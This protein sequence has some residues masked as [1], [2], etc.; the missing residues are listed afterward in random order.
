MTPISSIPRKSSTSI[1]KEEKEKE[2]EKEMEMEKEKEKEMEMDTET[3][4]GTPIPTVIFTPYLI[5]YPLVVPYVVIIR[6]NRHYNH[7][8]YYNPKNNNNNNNNNKNSDNT[9]QSIAIVKKLMKVL[10]RKYHFTPNY[11]YV[12]DC[13][14]HDEYKWTMTTVQS[15]DPN[16]GQNVVLRSHPQ[17]VTP[18]NINHNN[19]YVAIPESFITNFFKKYNDL[20]YIDNKNNEQD[21][22]NVNDNDNDHDTYIDGIVN[23]IL[24]GTRLFQLCVNHYKQE[25]QE[26]NDKY[27]KHRVKQKQKQ[28]QKTKQQRANT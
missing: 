22:V 7:Y 17:L 9:E 19:C 10:G 3:F 2:K 18:I 14:T 23:R 12:I 1:K 26:Y 21:N 6:D 25:E 13:S 11:E 28:K 20:L 8:N 27:K 16:T 15:V 24:C 4:T 5:F